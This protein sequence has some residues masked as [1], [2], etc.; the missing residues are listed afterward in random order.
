MA[1]S[2]AQVSKWA[3]AGSRKEALLQPGKA[4][5]P[6]Q[7]HTGGGSPGGSPPGGELQLMA[8]RA[9]VKTTWQWQCHGHGARGI[10]VRRAAATSLG[11]GH[12]DWCGRGASSR[13]PAVHNVCV[14][15]VTGR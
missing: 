12:R 15:R 14:D 1:P 10:P 7:G 2:F 6:P 9:G 4:G 5:S 13:R 8:R 11:E 3:V